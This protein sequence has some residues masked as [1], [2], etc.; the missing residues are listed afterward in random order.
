MNALLAVFTGVTSGG[1]DLIH[2]LVGFLLLV[3]VIAVFIIAARWLCALAGLTIPQPLMLIL[4]ILLFVV[5]LLMLL[6]W[7]GVYRW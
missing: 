6:S 4:G 1:V 3:C 5:L 7:S 2:F